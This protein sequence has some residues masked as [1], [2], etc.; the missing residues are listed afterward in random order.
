MNIKYFEIY[1][2][3]NWNLDTAMYKL[4]KTLYVFTLLDKVLFLVNCN[5]FWWQWGRLIQVLMYT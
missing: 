1:L 5:V 2:K 3:F 4:S